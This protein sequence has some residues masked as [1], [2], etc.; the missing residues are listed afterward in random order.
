MFFFEEAYINV[1]SDAR[2]LISSSS[3]SLTLVKPK[4]EHFEKVNGF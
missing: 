3:K 1:E 4:F 2:P